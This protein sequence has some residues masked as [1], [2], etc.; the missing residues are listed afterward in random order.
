MYSCANGKQQFELVNRMLVVT[1]ES[2]TPY[3][4]ER[5]QVQ[6]YREG[7]LG[8]IIIIVIYI[9]VSRFFVVLEAHRCGGDT[10]R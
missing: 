1:P 6:E 4:E 5:F 8:P 2:Q 3:L 7:D 10:V 9:C